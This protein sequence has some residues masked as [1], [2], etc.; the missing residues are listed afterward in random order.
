MNDQ[1]DELIQHLKGIREIV[2][3]KCYGGFGISHEAELLYLKRARIDYTTKDRTSRDETQR[4]GP[5]IFV[6]DKEWSGYEI[7]RDDPVLISVIK[8]LGQDSWGN[9]SELKIIKIPADVDWD[10]EQHDGVEWVVE[11]HRKWY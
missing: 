4:Y 10:I 6:D 2:I 9:F 1:H 8:E 11:V 7:S 5:I 3:N